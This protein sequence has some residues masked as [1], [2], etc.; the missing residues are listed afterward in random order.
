MKVGDIVRTKMWGK[1]GKVFDIRENPIIK[2]YIITVIFYRYE[3]NQNGKT[4]FVSRSFRFEES[5]LIKA[6]LSEILN[7]NMSYT[8]HL[9]END[10]E[11]FLL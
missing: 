2:N 10:G 5:E 3:I 11:F 8:K 4:T 1:V 7:Y 9:L 6:N